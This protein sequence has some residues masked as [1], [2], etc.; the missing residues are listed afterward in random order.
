MDLSIINYSVDERIATIHLK[1]K[2][3]YNA[4]SI[5]MAKEITYC[6][7]KANEDI[8]VNVVIIKGLDKA[9]STGGD[10]REFSKE[11]EESEDVKFLH[12]LELWDIAEYIRRMDKIVICQMRGVAAG[13][14]VSLVTACD[15]IIAEENAY[16]IESFVNMGITP[17]MGGAYML[18]KDIGW[19][20]TMEYIILGDKIPAKDLHNL[21]VI[22]KI[23][24]AD[25]LED[26]VLNLA[27]RLAKGPLLSYRNAKRLMYQVEFK[28]FEAY[29]K[30]EYKSNHELAN[31]NDYKNAIK[32]FLE[33]R[34]TDYEGR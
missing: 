27:K 1:N 24:K 32:A 26:E 18:A 23:T 5:Q 2:E 22:Y 30:A 16:F 31:T 12:M 3:N 21:G 28:D 17:G 7:K 25:D 14:G 15:F 34:P 10:I 8:G 33:K 4:L 6:L 9:L 19:H 29:S 20:K 11:I 13:A